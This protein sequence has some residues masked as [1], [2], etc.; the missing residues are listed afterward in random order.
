MK[1]HWKYL[2]Y[3]MRHK[4]FVL[5]ACRKLRVPL[6]RA[7]VHDW[8][9]FLPSEWFPYVRF[10]NG[11][12]QVGDV[13]RVDCIDGFGGHAEIIDTR[14][15]KLSRYKV[16]FWHEWE[17]YH[18]EF[19]AHDFEVEGLDEAKAAFD[20]AWLKHQN[21][22]PH[23]W[24]YWLL[25]LDDGGTHRLQMPEVFVREMVADWMGAGRALGFP[26]TKGWY[27]RNR[28]NIQ[29]HDRTRQQVENLLQMTSWE[30]SVPNE[31]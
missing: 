6:W 29:L 5:L 12:P 24:Q 19:W 18:Q 31:G 26:D 21:R 20:V 25:T 15:D 7:V 10:F 11:L 14:N 28:D 9:K 30:E 4:W 27:E 13:V 8:S 2:V 22:Q 3:L 23:H 16:R 17:S 1:A